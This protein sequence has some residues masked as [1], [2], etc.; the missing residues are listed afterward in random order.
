VIP[1]DRLYPLNQWNLIFTFWDGHGV[2]SRYPKN[3]YNESEIRRLAIMQK[4][5]MDARYVLVKDGATW[6][7]MF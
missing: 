2:V 6:L 7:T 4:A 1:A 5:N 3:L